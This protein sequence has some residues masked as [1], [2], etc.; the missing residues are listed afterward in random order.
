[1]QTN[2]FHYLCNM[3]QTFAYILVLLLFPSCLQENHEAEA[4]SHLQ[5]GY[6]QENADKE[7][8]AMF[9]YKQAEEA[10]QTVNNRE[11][12]FLIYTAI[13]KLNAKHAH[14]ELATNYFRKAIDLKLSVPIW[15]T[16]HRIFPPYFFEK[17]RFKA[18]AE[19]FT[20]LIEQMDFASPEAIRLQQILQYKEEREWGKA[21]SALQKAIASTSD[22]DARCRLY[23]ELADVYLQTNK[24]STADSLYAH[25]LKTSSG[26]L[27]ASIYKN[28]YLHHQANGQAQKT[29]E[30]LLKYV[31]ELELLYATEDRADLLEI[32]KQYD[33]ISLMKKNEE[34]RRQWT[35]GL[36]STFTIIISLGLLIGVI[37]KYHRKQKEELLYTYKKEAYALQTQI[38]KLQ[39]QMEENEDESIN[40]QKQI[41][42]LE[43]EKQEKDIR[44]RQ[45]EVTFRGKRM[46]LSPENAE[47]VQLYLNLI[48]RTNIHYH[49]SEDRPILAHWLNISQDHWAERLNSHYPTLSNGEKD[50]CY[51]FAIGFS[52]DEMA[53]LLQ[54]QPR[55]VDRVVYR[56]CRKMGLS[57]GNK[58]DFVQT[59]N[60]LNTSVKHI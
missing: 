44:I 53:D 24:P 41:A 48:N 15:H 21:D 40:L 58:E 52:L 36:L 31:Q 60:Q 42:S 38:D 4:I 25:A 57:Q 56:I 14:Y 26:S 45:L 47:A 20:R 34:Y 32:E 9:H 12:H 28:R 27:K 51:L 19:S 10:I 5:K 1:M 33:Y 37:W 29:Q 50:I 55:S 22:S 49:P 6:E 16:M 30:Y 43:T 7:V 18:H 54:I 3:K 13:G 46:A 2:S 35:I 8:E 11:L 17:K 39:E 23:A 59:L